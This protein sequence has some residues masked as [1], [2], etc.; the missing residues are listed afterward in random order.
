[1][2]VVD[3]GLGGHLLGLSVERLASRDPAAFTEYGHLL[4]TFV[5]NEILKQAS[6][7]D[8][9]LRFGHFRTH[10]GE[11]ADLVVERDDGSVSAV[12]VK[13]ASRVVGDDLKGLRILRERLGDRFLGGVVLYSGSRAYS[14]EDRISV[15]PLDELW[16]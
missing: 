8:T 7:S 11:E 4:E 2:N 9:L 14:P 5:V 10:D 13:A 1:M 12:E 15:A 3:T 6:W 16:V